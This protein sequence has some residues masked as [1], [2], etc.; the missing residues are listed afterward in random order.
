MRVKHSQCKDTEIVKAESQQMKKKTQNKSKDDKNE[1]EIHPAKQPSIGRTRSWLVKVC[2]VPLLPFEEEFAP[3][4]EKHQEKKEAGDQSAA[5]AVQMELLR[6][7][8]FISCRRQIVPVEA[9]AEGVTCEEE[10]FRMDVPRF[11]KWLQTPEGAPF[12]ARGKGFDDACYL[13]STL[14]RRFMPRGFSAFHFHKD[15]HTQDCILRGFLK[16]TGITAADE[17]EESNATAEVDSFMFKGFCRADANRFAVTT[18]SNGENGKYMVRK[19]FGEWYIFAGSKNTGMVWHT[20]RKASTIYPLVSNSSDSF[21]NVGRKIANYV[22]TMISA[23][24][25]DSQH[26]FMENIDARGAT[27]MIEFNDPQNE[28]IFPIDATRA[29]HVALLDREGYPLPQSE[30]IEVFDKYDLQRVT[31]DIHED[32]TKLDQAISS[33]RQSTEIEGVVIYLERLDCTPVGLIK[34]KSDYYVIARSTRETMRGALVSAVKKGT[35]VESALSTTSE[36]LKKRMGQLTHVDGCKEKHAGWAS[37]ACEFAE[38]WANLYKKATD[39]EKSSLI[40]EFTSKYGS[41]YQRF[42]KQKDAVALSQK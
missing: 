23:M 30:A 5:D 39:D 4:L 18:K 17:D 36:R 7:H 22:G 6:K 26:E 42:R 9:L 21:A 32:I 27:V 34:V 2:G 20:D 10:S 35:P 41:L 29:D 38:H 33:V 37:F 8:P 25:P 13:T 31:C 1:K 14:L 16:F 3:L 28:H 24:S 11:R 40:E 15:G 19:V 12:A